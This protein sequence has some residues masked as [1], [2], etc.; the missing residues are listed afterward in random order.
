MND[1]TVINYGTLN[2]ILANSAGKNKSFTCPICRI[3]FVDQL[4]LD[5]NKK[6]EHSLEAE[7][8]AGLG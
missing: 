8:P 1:Q 3:N 5:A 2:L 6:K 7:S 4:T